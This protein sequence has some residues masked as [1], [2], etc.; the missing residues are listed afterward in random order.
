MAGQ[1]RKTS[2]YSPAS[3]GCKL[4]PF[5]DYSGL[6]LRALSAAILAIEISL[7]GGAFITL[8]RKEEKRK[9]EKAL[10]ITQEESNARM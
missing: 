4:C 1:I 3:H 5:P 7:S 6:C 8:E 9:R 2:L 10:L